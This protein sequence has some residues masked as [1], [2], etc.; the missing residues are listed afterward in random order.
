MRQIT[1]RELKNQTG[2]ALEWASRGERVLVTRRGKPVAW[3]V[4][5]ETLQEPTDAEQSWQEILEA[6]E[7]QDPHYRDWQS[8]VA[9]SRGR[10]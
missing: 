8:A 7:S 10:P 9:A 3:I 4:P 2:K 6:L 1:A 5:A